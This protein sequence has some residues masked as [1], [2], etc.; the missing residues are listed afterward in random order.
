M[1][2][3]IRTIG[4]AV[5]V[6]MYVIAG[7]LAFAEA[8]ILVGMV[9]PGETALL[10]AGV[11]AQ[12]GALNVWIL[13]VVAVFAA[14]AGDSTGFEFGRKFGPPLRRSRLGG[15]VGEHRWRMVDDFLHEHSGKSVFLGRL[16]A[17]FRALVPSMA[18]MSGMRYRTFVVW[19]VAG[20]VLWAPGVVL[21]GYAFSKSLSTVGSTLTWAPFVLVAAVVLFYLA[22]H[23]R[24]RRKERAAAEETAS[25]RSGGG[26]SSGR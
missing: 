22:L 14:I 13:I 8:S 12:Q 23:L 9:L 20:A 15:W 10:V 18:G 7:G 17:V 6:W 25:T 16:T 19:N 1:E 3:F 4:N 11:F 24:N 21:L 5:G 2:H 26:D